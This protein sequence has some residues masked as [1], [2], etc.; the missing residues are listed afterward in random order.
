[1]KTDDF[2]SAV[3]LLKSSMISSLEINL[4]H[5]LYKR[6][7]TSAILAVHPT[8]PYKILILLGILSLQ[9]TWVYFVLNCCIEKVASKNGG[10]T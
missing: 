3:R 10:P 8:I 4:C 6:Y 2:N 7:R 9:F 1:M 5:T